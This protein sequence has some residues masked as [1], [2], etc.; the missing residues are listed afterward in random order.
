[1]SLSWH[2]RRAEPRREGA[3]NPPGRTAP[4]AQEKRLDIEA[5]YDRATERVAACYQAA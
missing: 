5:R 4:T 3:W 2:D 1:M